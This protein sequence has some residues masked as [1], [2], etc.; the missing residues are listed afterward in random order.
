MMVL[1]QVREN[2]IQFSLINARVLSRGS[3]APLIEARLIGA[4]LIRRF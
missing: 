3:W 2:Y 1:K 4:L